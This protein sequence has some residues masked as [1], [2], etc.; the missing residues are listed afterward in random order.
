MLYEKEKLVVTSNFSFSH[1]HFKRLVLQTNVVCLKKG[2]MVLKKEALKN[3]CKS[4]L[5]AHDCIRIKNKYS[6]FKIKG[7]ASRLKSFIKGNCS[8]FYKIQ[9]YNMIISLP[10]YP[11][12]KCWVG[13]GQ[14]N[15]FLIQALFTNR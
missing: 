8:A 1:S 11:R 13:K 2:L 14:T 5:F 15:N 3:M 6:S 9:K 4:R 10:T 7:C 12:L